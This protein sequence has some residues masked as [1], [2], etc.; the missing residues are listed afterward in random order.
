A[1]LDVKLVLGGPLRARKVPLRAGLAI[2]PPVAPMVN[3]LVSDGPGAAA[4]PLVRQ[5][6]KTLTDVVAG[7][8]GRYLILT[9]HESKQ[10]AIFDANA[11]D[12]VK[13]IDIPSDTV[14]VAAGADYLILLFPK[15]GL[16]QR[17]NLNSMSVEIKGQK[18]PI[19]AR[20]H[21]IAMGCDSDGPILAY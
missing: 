6:D 19:A 12:F 21:N 20:I 10:I 18:A 1:A 4:E 7:G 8:G 11:A 15:E 2:R 9:V 16:F 3:A 13:R 5:F 14:L 17:W